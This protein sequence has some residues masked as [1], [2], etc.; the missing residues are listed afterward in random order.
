MLIGIIK[1]A[2]RL[3]S[4]DL[5][6]GI[7]CR[8][9]NLIVADHSSHASVLYRYIAGRFCSGW[10]LARGSGEPWVVRDS[11]GPG[12]EVGLG[13]LSGGTGMWTRIPSSFR[14]SII[15]A[16]PNQRAGDMGLL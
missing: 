10:C 14:R 3:E 16:K 9:G 5:R 12:F 11:Q 1:S 6:S 7:D 13:G 4:D 2:L 8:S 15:I